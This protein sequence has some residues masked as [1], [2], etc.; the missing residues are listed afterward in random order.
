MQ[1]IASGMITH[2]DAMEDAARLYWWDIHREDDADADMEAARARIARSR[3]IAE[4]VQHQRDF[5][6]LQG[7]A[8]SEADMLAVATEIVDDAFSQF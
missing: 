4:C 8:A 2:Q 5:Y 3:A 6:S 7:I 1:A